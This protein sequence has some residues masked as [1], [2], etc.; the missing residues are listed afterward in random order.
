VQLPRGGNVGSKI[1][2]ILNSH[3][4]QLIFLLSESSPLLS[5]R[6]DSKQVEPQFGQRGLG[7]N[8]IGASLHLVRSRLGFIDS[9]LLEVAQMQ[10]SP[11]VAKNQKSF[12]LLP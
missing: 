10:P 3:I 9:P 1:K 5:L 12:G 11:P 7:T 8:R 2:R 4:L 6:T